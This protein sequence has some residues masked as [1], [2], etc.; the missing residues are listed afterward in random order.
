[1]KRSDGL[2]R[3]AIAWIQFACCACCVLSF[4]GCRTAV[5][6]YVWRPAVFNCPPNAKIAIAPIAGNADLA[7]RVEQ[8]VMMQRPAAREDL[9]LD[10]FNPTRQPILPSAW[11]RPPS[12][13]SDLTALQAAKQARAD[14][15]LEGEVLSANLIDPENRPP[16]SA[17]SPPNEHMLVSWASG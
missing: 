17:D 15:L 11:S 12:L 13:Q 7:N 4:C 1:M 3:N 16:A 5:P 14:L 8:A 6:I 10:R 2:M 9:Q